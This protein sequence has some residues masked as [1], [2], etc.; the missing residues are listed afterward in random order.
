[1]AIS[2]EE[3]DFVC[4]SEQF[5]RQNNCFPSD[6]DFFEEL[7]LNQTQVAVNLDSEVVLK[8]LNAR[9]IDPAQTKDPTQS[10][11]A[12]KRKGSLNRLSDIQLAAV[13]TI[14]NPADVRSLTTKLESLGISTFTYNGWKKNPVFMKYLTEQ[15]ESLFSENMSE[16]HNSLTTRA[17]SGDIRATKLLYEVTGFWRGVQQENSGDVRMLVISLIEILQK[18]IKDPELLQAIAQDIQTV[19]MGIQ[20]GTQVLPGA[21]NSEISPPSLVKAEIE[22]GT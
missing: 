11:A 3:Y 13:S 10:K 18:H 21:P 7:G 12:K 22:V 14:L 15:G 2:P 4:F 9:G 17:V 1:M 6:T 8:H 16:I 19:Q 5:W 20:A